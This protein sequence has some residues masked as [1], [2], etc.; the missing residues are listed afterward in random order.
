MDG[1]I[2]GRK[3]GSVVRASERALC[4][5]GGEEGI[6]GFAGSLIGILMSGWDCIFGSFM[7]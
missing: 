2:D 5:G 4:L 3:E 7:G 1:W 6:L